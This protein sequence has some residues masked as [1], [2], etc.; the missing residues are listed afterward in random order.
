MSLTDSGATSIDAISPLPGLIVNGVTVGKIAERTG[1]SEGK[2]YA[3]LREFSDYL[4][5]ESETKGRMPQDQFGILNAIVLSEQAGHESVDATRIQIAALKD[6]D[7][8]EV[9]RKQLEW[10]KRHETSGDAPVLSWVESTLDRKMAV[11]NPARRHHWLKESLRNAQEF[12]AWVDQHRAAI[13][14]ALFAA[15][16]NN[17]GTALTLEKLWSPNPQELFNDQ[18]KTLKKSYALTLE[19]FNAIQRVPKAPVEVRV[20]TTSMFE[21]AFYLKAIGQ[22]EPKDNGSYWTAKMD[23]I[24]NGTRSAVAAAWFADDLVGMIRSTISIGMPGKD[25]QNPELDEFAQR[26]KEK[27]KRKRRQDS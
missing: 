3:G 24:L 8:A 25:V 27:A 9:I 10:R 13:S 23:A 7:G 15:G 19:A 22:E 2:V 20:I 18:G 11:L 1:V 4:N 16:K 17:Y 5:G 21:Y 12:D 14:P 6:L 26:W